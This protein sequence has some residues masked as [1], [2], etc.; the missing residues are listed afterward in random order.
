MT[1]TSLLIIAAIILFINRNLIT[2]A[3]RHR[4]AI[5]NTV[6]GVVIHVVDGDTIKVAIDGRVETVRYIGVNT[7]EIGERGYKDA[8]E[9]NR[10]LVE[11]K[12]VRMGSDKQDTDKYG[13][14]LRYVWVGKKLVNRELY[15]QGVAKLM[16]IEPNTRRIGEIA[17]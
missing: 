16:I 7:P 9:T 17:S 4:H 8:T 15:R 14:K 3:Y 1:I 6:S 2:H 10:R 11:G 12:R 5:S 13:R